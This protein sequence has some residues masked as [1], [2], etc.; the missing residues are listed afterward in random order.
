MLTTASFTH[1]PESPI[2][3]LTEL[4]DE[5]LLLYD[6]SPVEEYADT[7]FHQDF[8]L[9]NISLYRY[10]LHNQGDRLSGEQE[11]VLVEQ[12]RLGDADAQT[13]LATSLFYGVCGI[14]SR[15]AQT[16]VWAS[17]RIDYMELVQM[18]N[19]TV[20]EVMERALS[21]DNPCAYLMAAAK[22]EIAQFCQRYCSPISTG[23]D[24]QGHFLPALSVSSLDVLLSSA[25][26]QDGITLLDLLACPHQE[27]A[28]DEV[29]DEPELPEVMHQKLYHAVEALPPSQRN[30]VK[31]YFGL[32][33]YPAETLDEISRA[34]LPV[35]K[36]AVTYAPGLAVTVKRAALNNLEKL[37]TSGRIKWHPDVEKPR[38]Q[39]LDAAYASLQAPGKRVTSRALSKAAHVDTAIALEYLNQRNEGAT[40]RNQRLDAAYASLQVA[41]KRIS[42]RALRMTA[43]VPQIVAADYLRARQEAMVTT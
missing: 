20:L 19:M 10:D 2:V 18:G 15:Y 16:Y 25:S 4:S 33:E 31:R 36:T 40:A 24:T 27:Q 17:P 32:S 37:L 8:P 22:Y 6:L 23:R 3:A 43:H 35:Q 11:A 1:G 34:M 14:A 13:K 39:R 29:T 5:E 28:L 30:V 26:S 7:I 41:G 9:D 42:S 21:R 12:A 38:E